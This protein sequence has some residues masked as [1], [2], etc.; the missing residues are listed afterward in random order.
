MFVNENLTK[1]ATDRFLTEDDM[2]NLCS[3][4]CFA[5]QND[6][7]ALK[8]VRSVRPRYARRFSC[9]WA[10]RTRCIFSLW[11]WRR[12]AQNRSR[13]LRLIAQQRTVRR[14]MRFLNR[15]GGRAFATDDTNNVRRSS[16]LSALALSMPH[17]DRETRLCTFD[18]VWDWRFTIWTKLIR[19]DQTKSPR[20]MAWTWSTICR[21][22]PF[23]GLSGNNSRY[24]WPITSLK[25]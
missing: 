17:D 14:T 10:T 7:Y 20:A 6:T 23:P 12:V 13:A 2:Q 15:E 5:W 9:H 4:N 11:R 21:Y 16:Q 3:L 25:T 22:E 8:F 1:F 18:R 19:W 24:E